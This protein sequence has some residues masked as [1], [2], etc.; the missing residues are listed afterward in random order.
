MNQLNQYSQTNYDSFSRDRY[1]SDRQQRNF[2]SGPRKTYIAPRENLFSRKK[3]LTRDRLVIALAILLIGIAAFAGGRA[4]FSAITNPS[5]IIP[6]SSDQ[7]FTSTP[8]DEW[9]K[10]TMPTLYQRDSQWSSVTYGEGIVNDSGCG[11]TCM[12]MVYV[13]LTGKKDMN[14]GEM[15]SYAERSGFSCEAGT[16]WAFFTDGASG[17][18]LTG[19]EVPFDE[20][21]ITAKLQEGIPIICSVRE[22][23]FTTSGHLIVLAGLNDEGEVIVHDPNSVENTQRGWTL[24]TIMNQTNNMWYFTKTSWF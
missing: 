11:P 3:F 16:E 12:S 20:G 8:Q 13:F 23:D 5:N 6:H 22:G 15:A 18:G 7:G 19:Q 17:L 4:I 24:Q 9:K 10:G 1:V 14:P 21:S 2:K